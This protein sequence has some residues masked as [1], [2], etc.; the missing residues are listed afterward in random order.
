MVTLDQIFPKLLVQVSV[1]EIHNRLVSDPV[2]GGLKEAIDADNNII[3][4]DSTSCSI[5]PPQHKK[6]S[7]VKG[8][9][10]L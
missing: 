6:F 4:S 9:V 7:T 5:L 3:I 2:N 10:W 8:H 1:R